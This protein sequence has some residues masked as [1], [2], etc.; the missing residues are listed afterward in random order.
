MKVVCM[1]PA[2]LGSKRVVNK[3]IMP[4]GGQPLMTHIIRTAKESGCFHE[5]YLNSE[6]NKLGR[7]ALMEGALHYKR[8]KELAS[9]YATNDDFTLEFLENIDCDYVVQLLT[10]SPFVTEQE[11]REFTS[12]LIDN[13]LDT[14]ISVKDSQ[15]ECLYEGEAINFDK[16]KPTPPSQE[17]VPIKAY[18][19]ALMG[20]KKD[21]FIKNM[22]KHG[23]AYHGGEGK[24]DYFT[25]KG[26]SEI[27]ID[28][29][30]DLELA[31]AV[32]SYTNGN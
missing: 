26:F 2:R 12:Y 15:I 20:W 1:I 17:L 5:V 21:T 18:A 27:D 8:P 23:C 4:L 24:T 32:W 14:L 6:A 19:C 28:T 16:L 10:T 31:R 11:I 30:E 9:D 22:K 7:I 3:N 29:Y 13:E 25:I